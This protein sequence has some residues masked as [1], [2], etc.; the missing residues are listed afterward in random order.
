MA[1]QINTKELKGCKSYFSWLCSKVLNEDS[2]D[3][4]TELMR[5]LFETE[6]IFELKDDE[7]RATDA[8]DLRK[9]YA[10]EIG[11]GVG[12]SE[13]DID[14]IWKSI[15]EKCSVLEMLVSLCKHLDLMVNEGEEGSMMPLFFKIMIENLGLNERDDEDFDVNSDGAKAFWK[16]KI[17]R[18]LNRKYKHDGS[19][20]GLFPLKKWSKKTEKDQRLVSVWYQM[21]AWLEENLDEDGY[22]IGQNSSN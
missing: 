13:R 8:L 22:F 18:F 4:S 6:F 2:S 11:S 15:H 9:A 20:G 5:I 1:V 7:I 3:I 21:N 19:D 12:K 16:N 10:E 17:D 14:R